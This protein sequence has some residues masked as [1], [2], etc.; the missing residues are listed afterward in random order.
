[1]GGSSCLGPAIVPEQL[2]ARERAVSTSTPIRT[3]ALPQLLNHIAMSNKPK[4]PS[5]QRVSAEKPDTTEREAEQPSQPAEQAQQSTPAIAE[6]PVPTE[7]D[8]EEPESIGLLDQAKRFLD[9]STIRD[10]PREKKVAFLE[11]K[12]V[13]AEDIETLLGAELPETHSSEL[14]AVG[15]RAWSTVSYRFTCLVPSIYD[16]RTIQKAYN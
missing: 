6:A 2:H 15:E 1:M 3:R 7:D 16:N 13:S 12:G 14:E 10:A 11:S 8:L 4:R 5:W 9:D